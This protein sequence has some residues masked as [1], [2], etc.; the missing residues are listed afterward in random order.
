MERRRRLAGWRKSTVFR[1]NT[2]SWIQRS[3]NKNILFKTSNTRPRTHHIF[4]AN[5]MRSARLC[6]AVCVCA[7]ENSRRSAALVWTNRKFV[8]HFPR[9][10]ARMPLHYSYA[11]DIPCD[12]LLTQSRLPHTV[13]SRERHW[14]SSVTRKKHTPNRRKRASKMFL[15]SPRANLRRT[16]Q[17]AD[18]YCVYTNTRCV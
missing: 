9:S 2:I 5:M 11:V 15:I 6:C 14:P 4:T 1:T 18:E 16:I 12:V 7:M 13:P 10:R 3:V 8:L 17:Q